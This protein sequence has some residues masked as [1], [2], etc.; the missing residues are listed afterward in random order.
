MDFLIYILI[1]C[2]ATATADAA[3]EIFERLFVNIE[4]HERQKPDFEVKRASHSVKILEACPHHAERQFNP[5][6]MNKKNSM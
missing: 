6:P 1:F 4:F 3:I 2:T 5:N